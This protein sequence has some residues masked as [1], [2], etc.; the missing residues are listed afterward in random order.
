MGMRRGRK[1]QGV[2][3]WSNYNPYHHGDAHSPG[4]MVRVEHFCSQPF[5]TLPLLLSH[6]E[7]EDFL[8]CPHPGGVEQPPSGATSLVVLLR[9][10]FCTH[11]DKGATLAGVRV[12]KVESKT[13]Q[14]PVVAA[15]IWPS[16]L[17]SCH[18]LFPSPFHHHSFSSTTL[19]DI[20]CWSSF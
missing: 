9:C 15:Q 17:V 19:I 5:L 6:Q 8:L 16:C 14:S 13:K 2:V 12:F 10:P 4:L 3:R 1:S 18:A 7:K 20:D 11:S